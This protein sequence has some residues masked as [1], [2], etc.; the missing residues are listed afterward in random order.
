MKKKIYFFSLF[1]WNTDLLWKKNVLH[2][3]HMLALAFQKLGYEITFIE[4]RYFGI[5]GFIP[6]KRQ[7]NG[8]TVLTVYGLPYLR[9]KLK[10]IFTLNDLL[11]VRQLKKLISSE[12]ALF[13]VSVP[14]WAKVALKLRGKGSKVIY[15]L[16][17]DF[18]AF[19]KGTKWRNIL[20]AYEQML[21]KNAD[22][23]AVT[24]SNLLEK[25]PSG[26]KTILAEN[27]IDLVAFEKASR[28]KIAGTQGKVIGYIGALNDWVDFDLIAKIATKLPDDTVVLIGPTTL[29]TKL[30]QLLD[31]S[32]NIKWLGPKGWA[33]IPDFFASLDIGL[34]PFKTEKKYP[35]LKTANSN[36]IYQYAFFG[37]PIVSTKFAQTEKLDGILYLSES[38][39]DFIDNLELAI[40]E[41]DQSMVKKRKEFARNHDWQ[42]QAK[43]ILESLGEWYN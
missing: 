42:K 13:F 25:V 3:E 30:N 43:L 34:V 36:K 32:K 6:K 24:S 5:H 8:I 28:A 2:R 37:Y 31:K 4:R 16:S 20:R 38:E 40:H 9:G 1:N 26:Q 39:E 33:Q 19:T 29:P 22:M 35:R 11:L 27:G 15:D 23:V 10:F 14:N 18:L 21:T 12:Q 17:D 41:K 7:E